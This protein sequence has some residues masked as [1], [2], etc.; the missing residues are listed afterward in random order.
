LN[1]FPKNHKED[2][3]KKYPGAGNQAIDLLNKM[4]LFNPYFRITIDEALDHP[5]F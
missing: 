4:L 2:L 1:A 3:S 5:F